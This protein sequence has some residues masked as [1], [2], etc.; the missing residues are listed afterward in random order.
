MSAAIDR[1]DPLWRSLFFENWKHL[2]GRD[3][4]PAG[5][6]IQ[7]PALARSAAA[8][9]DDAMRE[10]VGLGEPPACETCNGVG[11]ERCSWT[12]RTYE[13]RDADPAKTCGGTAPAVNV[14]PH[15]AVQGQESSTDDETRIQLSK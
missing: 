9:A 3:A 7:G 6:T 11:C 8:L 10:A 2:L 4:T 15:S 5:S 1:K 12:G 13:C 14:R